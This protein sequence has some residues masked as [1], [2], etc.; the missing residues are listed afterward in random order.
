MH[1]TVLAVGTRGDVQPFVAVGSRLKAEGH[2]VRIGTH[3]VHEAF[4][5]GYGLEFATLGENP[6]DLMRTH[7]GQKWLGSGQNPIRFWREFYKLVDRTVARGLGD[8]Q[9]ACQGTDAIIY[10]FFGSAGMHMAETLSV[11]RIFALL[12]PFTRTRAFAAPQIPPLLPGG[13]YNRL[14]YVLAEQ[15]AWQMGRRWIN[16]W[17]THSLGLPAIPIRGPMRDLYRSGEPY[18]YGFSEHV[19]PRPTDWPAVHRVSGYWFLDQGSHWEPPEALTDFL[20]SG[21]PPVYLGF[22]SVTGSVA[23]RML[24]LSLEAIGKTGQRAILLGGWAEAQRLES[25]D[26]I[27]TLTS[28]PHDWLF[29]QVSAV[30]HHGGAGTTAAGLRAGR[31]TLVLPFFADQP[32][33]GRRVHALGAGPKP[34]SP[35]KLTADRLAQAIQQTATDRAMR[36]RAAEVGGRIRGED[37]IDRAAEIV[38]DHFTR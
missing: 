28:A 34:L 2:S 10:T 13:V 23:R 32:F 19:V 20:A 35:K 33:W 12:Q 16:R 36:A 4:V 26:R 30:V 31:P 1:I 18:L 5:R 15:M 6:Q 3:Q 24:H 29:P 14:T 37:G 21:P 22:G 38:L 25:Y 8:A 7:T 17:R 27:L 9:A 11:P